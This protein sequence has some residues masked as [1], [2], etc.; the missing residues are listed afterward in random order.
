MTKRNTIAFAAA[1]AVF[2]CAVLFAFS[3]EPQAAQ[4]PAPLFVPWGEYTAAPV[5]PAAGTQ[6][7]APPPPSEPAARAAAPQALTR[8]SGF[9]LAFNETW[10]DRVT[11]MTSPLDGTVILF[12]RIFIRNNVLFPVARV[13]LYTTGEYRHLLALGALD[14]PAEGTHVLYEH[15]GYA[16]LFTVYQELP[17]EGFIDE[18]VRFHWNYFREEIFNRR[19]TVEWSAEPQAGLRLGGFYPTQQGWDY[20]YDINRRFVLPLRFTADEP[21]GLWEDRN[22]MVYTLHA[23]QDGDLLRLTVTAQSVFLLTFRPEEGGGAGFLSYAE[24]AP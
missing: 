17:S 10:Q 4:T 15:E 18:M 7:P 11:L 19:F 21:R 9:T 22:P 3:D 24:I 5:P 6:P 2:V 12:V 23:E 14:P 20:L 16:L 8:Q 13:G 1:A